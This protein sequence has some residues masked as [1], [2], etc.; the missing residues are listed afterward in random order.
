M[1][2]GIMT[3]Y[4]TGAVAVVASAAAVAGE[5]AVPGTPYCRPGHIPEPLLV[6]LP[7]HT[8]VLDR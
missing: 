1:R 7:E 8:R 6:D 3:R 5:F 2:P 4:S